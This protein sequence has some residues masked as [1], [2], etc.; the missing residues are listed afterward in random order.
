MTSKWMGLGAPT[1]MEPRGRAAPL[2]YRLAAAR[3]GQAQVG[4]SHVSRPR[5]TTFVD[6][7]T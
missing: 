7:T 3:R 1:R 4:I 2:P 6:V 5:A